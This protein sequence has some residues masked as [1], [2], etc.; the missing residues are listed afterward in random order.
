MLD[1]GSWSGGF[2]LQEGTRCA[3]NGEMRGR[4]RCMQ[5]GAPRSLTSPNFVGSPSSPASRER[6]LGK[7]ISID[8]PTL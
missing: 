2:K 7:L 3:S 6:T 4:G 1:E 5:F 8:S